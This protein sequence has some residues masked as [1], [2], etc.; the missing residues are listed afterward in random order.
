MSTSSQNGNLA[1][2]EDGYINTIPSKGTATVRFPDKD[3]FVSPPYQMITSRTKDNQEHD[4]YKVGEHVLCLCMG[5][6]MESGYILGAVY[7]ETNLPIT[8]NPKMWFKHFEDGSSMMCDW[9][10]NILQIRDSFGSFILFENGS[11]TIQAINIID[12][13]PGR[14]VLPLGDHISALFD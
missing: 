5:N 6:G 3:D 13:N 14:Q 12:L 10:R 2:I 1:I 9:E 4:P 11:I 8:D 7:D